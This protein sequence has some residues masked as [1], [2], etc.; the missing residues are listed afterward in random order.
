MITVIAGTNRP[1]SRTRLVAKTIVELLR[2]RTEEPVEFLSLEDLP[3]DF[4]HEAMYSAEGQSKTLG[5]LQDRYLIPATKLYFVAP[6]YNGGIPGILK[7]FL[8]ACSIR[9]YAGTFHG[10]KKAALVGVSSGRSGCLRGMEYMTG[11][12]NYLKIA[13]LPNKLPISGIDKLITDNQLSDANT[14]KVLEAQVDEFLG[15]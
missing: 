15:F 8:D 6:E 4:L 1:N 5:E 10:D 2:A 14:L 12:L 9:D 3:N 11:F 13:V 7:L